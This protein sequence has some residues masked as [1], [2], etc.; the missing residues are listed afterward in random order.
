MLNHPQNPQLELSKHK[1]LEV[2]IGKCSNPLH[3][4]Y[5]NYK[6]RL[7]NNLIWFISK[8]KEPFKHVCQCLSSMA[9]KRLK[10]HLLVNA[11][12]CGIWTALNGEALLVS[13]QW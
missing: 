5:V 8:T 13:V 3:T 12:P 4:H 1:C 2:R 7:I 6:S 9:F 10:Q 11:F